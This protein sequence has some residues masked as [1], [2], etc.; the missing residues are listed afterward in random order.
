MGYSIQQSA[1]TVA[2]VYTVSILVFPSIYESQSLYQ[3]VSAVTIQH[4]HVVYQPNFGLRYHVKLQTDNQP[5]LCPI[6][7]WI[8]GP[9]PEPELPS[10]T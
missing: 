3:Y 6:S 2:A 8:D 1:A 7:K 9:Q 10:S 5:V 4:A